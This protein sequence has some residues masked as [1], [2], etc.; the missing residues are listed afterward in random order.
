MAG[1]DKLEANMPVH[2][3]AGTRVFVTRVIR[4]LQADLYLDALREGDAP[5]T[6]EPGHVFELR[7]GDGERSW[8]QAVRVREVLD[9]IPILVVRLEGEARRIEQR[10]APRAAVLAPLEYALMRSDSEIYTTTTLD[11]STVGLRFPCAFRPWIGLDLRMR[12]TLNQ[13]PV[14]LIG[15]VTRVAHASALVRGRMSWET[16]VQYQIPTP[17]A[18]RRIAEVVEQALARQIAARRG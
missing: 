12:L 13:V 10:H 2:L 14:S 3:Y 11:L 17:M 5:F 7:Y 1:L 18:R 8:K 9:P 16:A 4:R 15:R 6:P